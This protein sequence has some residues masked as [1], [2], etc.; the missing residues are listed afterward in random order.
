MQAIDIARFY[1]FNSLHNL[2]LRNHAP[3]PRLDTFLKAFFDVP[4]IDTDALAKIRQTIVPICNA[5]VDPNEDL[6]NSERFVVGSNKHRQARLIAFVLDDDSTRKVHFTENFFNQG[7]DWYNDGLTEPFD[8]QGHARAS[9]LIHEFAHQFAKAVDIAS[10]E[11]RRPFTDLISTITGY[12]AA[13][14]ESQARFQREA[15]SRATPH[16]ELFSV[17]NNERQK[18][19]GID[20]VPG[21]SHVS[22]EILKTTACTTLE[23]ARK[24]FLDSHN[25]A[26]RIDTILRNADSIALLICE[27]GR[28]LDPVTPA[29]EGLA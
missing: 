26:V 22:K 27:M 20:A 18:W 5:L 12:G 6:M 19:V 10:L 7:L 14:K 3:S 25:P 23:D 24:A 13:L 17:W 9:T 15:L 29:V 1:A 2:A 21:L 8:V 28:Q 16:E 11:A 4:R